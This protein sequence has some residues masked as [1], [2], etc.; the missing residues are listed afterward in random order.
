MK[1]K[2]NKYDSGLSVFVVPKEDTQAVT[3]IVLT[4]AGSNL[5]SNKELGLVH[6]L[7]HM[8]FKGTVKRPS[9]LDISLELDSFGAYYNAFTSSESTV[10]YI[11]VKKDFLTQAMDVISDIY[12]NSTLPELEIEKE[13]KVI[14]EE[15]NMRQDDVGVLLDDN[16]LSFL[17]PDSRAGIPVIGKKAVVDTITK[18]QLLNFKKKFYSANN[19]IIA[20]SGAVSEKEA[21]GLVEEYFVNLPQ[22]KEAKSIKPKVAKGP[23]LNVIYKKTDQSH[24]VASFLYKPNHSNIKEGLTYWLL[25]KVLGGYMSSRLFLK[26]REE[27]GLSYYISSSTNSNQSYARFD[28]S[29][30]FDPKNSDLALKAILDECKLIATELVWLGEID[31][32]RN[33]ILGKTAIAMENS[34][35]VAY[36]LTY[37]YLETGQVLTPLALEEELKKIT[38]EDLLKLAKKLLHP[39]SLH[40]SILGNV[41]SDKKLLKVIDEYQ[42]NI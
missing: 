40:I 7:E 12:L 16:H 9:Y 11:T 27:L 5:E 20:V 32:A 26:V 34:F 4:K 35:S 22:G 31:R 1:Y 15:I 38:A 13:K 23:R 6:L 29:A 28:I 36:D 41:K 42:I 25:A 19:T 8:C 37:Q 21:F 10:Y 2:F 14:R 17:Y 3:I 18:K 24:L 33:N 30:G 39:K